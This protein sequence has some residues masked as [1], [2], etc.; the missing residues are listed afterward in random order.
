MLFCKVCSAIL[1][2]P[3]VFVGAGLAVAAFEGEGLLAAGL[4][5]EA[6]LLAAGLFCCA[7]AFGGVAGAGFATDS[8]AEVEGASRRIFMVL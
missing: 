7:E 8:P 1:G 3:T 6:V 2:C 4:L 5:C